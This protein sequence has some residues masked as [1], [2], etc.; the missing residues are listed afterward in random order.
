M[1]DSSEG[2]RVTQDDPERG[3][4]ARQAA[5]IADRLSIRKYVVLGFLAHNT[6]SSPCALM[7]STACLTD[8][9]CSVV[10]TNNASGVSTTTIS[11]TPINAITRDVSVTTTP[12][13][14]SA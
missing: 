10:V 14:S 2:A 3:G 1:N 4:D 9:A 13:A 7:D 6:S 11:S 8:C 5:I 12:L